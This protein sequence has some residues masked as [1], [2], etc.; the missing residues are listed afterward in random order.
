VILQEVAV[1]F[2]LNLMELQ[3][4]PLVVFLDLQK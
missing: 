3:Q 2:L 1:Q 4:G